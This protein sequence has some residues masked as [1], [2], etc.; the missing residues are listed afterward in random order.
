[1]S[2]KHV[3]GTAGSLPVIQM[4]GDSVQS[5]CAG[6]RAGAFYLVVGRFGLE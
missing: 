3:N 2:E 4:T 5:R 6:T 1:M